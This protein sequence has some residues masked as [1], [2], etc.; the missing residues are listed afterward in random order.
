[1]HACS[2]SI[3]R[4]IADRTHSA[5]HYWILSKLNFFYF[6]LVVEV[7]VMGEKVAEN[8]LFFQY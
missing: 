2:G 7:V 8:I 4:I 3:S 5:T 6:V 1:M